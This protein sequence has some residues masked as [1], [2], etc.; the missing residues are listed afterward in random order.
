MMLVFNE[1]SA[2]KTAPSLHDAR[3]RMT[4]VSRAVAEL[5]AGRAV[6]LVTVECFDIYGAPLAE[7]YTLSRW[8]G[9]RS[10][11][12]D[13]RNYLQTI[14]TKLHMDKDL[15]EAV[16]DRFS[17]SEFHSR[18]REARGLGLAYLLDTAALSLPSEKFWRQANIGLRH[19]WLESDGTER[20]R[21]IEVINLSEIDHV[22]RVADAINE[23][24][25][26]RLREKP[27]AADRKLADGFPHLEF[28]LDA[29]Q[30]VT[31]LPNDIWSS[32]VTKLTVLDGAGRDWRRR[33]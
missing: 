23:K 10:V 22:R 28:G 30:Q 15:S 3:E 6:S 27:G 19:I 33:G 17:L 11:D 14:L 2:D 5:A 20:E 7:G 16:R 1:L 29:K 26:Q 9:D 4:G 32:V 31:A 24:S 18:D 8:L 21:D 25:R 12:R 13:R